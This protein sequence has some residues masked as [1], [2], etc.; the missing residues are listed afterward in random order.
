MRPTHEFTDPIGARTLEALQR[1]DSYS[2]WQVAQVSAFLGHRILE[3]GAGIGNI[4]A[5]LA[6][7]KPEALFITDPNPDY[8][9]RLR[10]AFE[11]SPTV[12]VAQLELPGMALDDWRAQRID[13]IVAFNVVEHIAEDH[14]AVRELAS[15]LM[16]GGR[17][18]LI[19]PAHSALYG[20]LDTALGHYRRYS[21]RS[22]GVL[23]A[24]A[25]L[26]PQ[27]VRYFNM[28]GAIGWFWRGQMRRKRELNPG[29]LRFFDKLVPLL[30][31]ED[32]L[33]KPFGLSVVAVA[34]R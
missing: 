2:A 5:H 1:T 10:S 15:T 20:P 29:S 30:R 11:R 3:I 33:P 9:S 21:V 24:Q 16:P 19:I 27:L 12:R 31:M 17:L 14:A 26:R 8:L 7:A 22:A 18:V 25:G 34:E 32:G 6:A 23:M 4:S 28:A 13:T